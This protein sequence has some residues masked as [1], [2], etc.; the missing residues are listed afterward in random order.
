M[1]EEPILF[2][3]VQDL[4]SSSLLHTSSM[5][6]HNQPTK[7]PDFTSAAKLKLKCKLF[8]DYGLQNS[9]EKELS[10]LHSSLEKKMNPKTAFQ[11]QPQI[12][13][14]PQSENGGSGVSGLI[15]EI[16]PKLSKIPTKFLIGQNFGG[17]MQAPSN[18]AVVAVD[19]HGKE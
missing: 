18:N 4:V 15:N 19:Y 8:S 16:N 7:T 5:F 3:T 17:S 13:P 10:S 11:S 14:Q 6:L 12:Q 2:S 9:E 1:S